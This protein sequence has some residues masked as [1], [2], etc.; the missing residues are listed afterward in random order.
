MISNNVSNLV[1]ISQSEEEIDGEAV[2]VDGEE[3]E[4]MV[5]VLSLEWIFCG[6]QDWNKKSDRIC[7]WYGSVAHFL[8][9]VRDL[10]KLLKMVCSVNITREG[11]YLAFDEALEIYGVKFIKQ[12]ITGNVVDDETMKTRIKVNESVCHCF[13]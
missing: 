8:A 4:S 3:D 6:T 11:H 9:Q 1:E 5:S 12:N 10:Q 13:L 2:G 7:T